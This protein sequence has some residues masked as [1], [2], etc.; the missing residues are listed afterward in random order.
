MIAPL[1]TSLLEAVDV[2]H[3]VL[4]VGVWLLL[5]AGSLAVVVRV[6]VALPP[7]YFEREQ[8]PRA[9]WTTARIARNLAGIG[10]IVVGAVLSLPGIPGQ[11]VL[12]MLAGILLVDFP[13]RR[14]LERRLLGRPGM[15]T[16]LN[17]LR[18]RFGRPPLR[19]P[20]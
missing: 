1:V 15:L 10:L 3:V 7:D 8:S 2:Q 14:A 18:A 17:R 6:V 19:T 12:T 5:T 13:R 16:T 4:A 9:R 11:G 20:R